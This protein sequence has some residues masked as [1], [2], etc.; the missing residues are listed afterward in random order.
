LGTGEVE[1]GRNRA[2][3]IPHIIKWWRA[4]GLRYSVSFSYLGYYVQMSIS[5]AAIDV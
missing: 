4:F 3:Q 2:Y 5:A 1:R